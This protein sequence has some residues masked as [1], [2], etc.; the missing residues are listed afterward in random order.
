MTSGGITRNLWI[1]AWTRGSDPTLTK[2]KH[3]MRDGPLSKRA[4]TRD[5]SQGVSH[6]TITALEDELV[7]G[8]FLYKMMSSLHRDN[9]KESSS[10]PH[11]N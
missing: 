1:G 8:P 5:T 6:L 9:L 2:L 11:K 4:K 7:Y 10:L 3:D